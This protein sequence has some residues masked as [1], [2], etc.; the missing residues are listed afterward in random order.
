MDTLFYT[1]TSYKDMV[2][3]Y[4]LPANV[5]AII[6]NLK[7]RLNI[8]PNVSINYKQKY[9]RNS[10]KTTWETLPTF[11]PTVIEEKQGTE[12]IMNDIRICL[13]KISLKNY[14]TN[15]NLIIDHINKLTVITDIQK[16][17]NNIF[18]IASTN[19]FFSE[20]YSKLYKELSEKWQ[21]FKDILSDFLKS[22]TTNI[23][24]IKYVD[25]NNDYDE[26]CKYNKINDARKATSV[27]IVNLVKHAVIPIDYLMDIIIEIQ[28]K[29]FEFIKENDKLHEVEEIT[30]NIFL[31]VTQSKEFAKTN[32]KWEIILKNI[33]TMSEYK[34]TNFLSLS[35]RSIF[36]YM[37]ILDNIQPLQ[38]K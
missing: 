7:K 5:L 22:Y 12:K 36:K 20:I 33:K 21:I 29:I 9:N 6:D 31:L 14:E 27:F 1:L 4:I 13:N 34:S 18:D 19:T 15:R 30:E 24:N 10:E 11:K 3:S 17:G 2:S 32:E 26:F 35:N 23:Y 28:D 16:I 8:K 25:S 38:K 37:D